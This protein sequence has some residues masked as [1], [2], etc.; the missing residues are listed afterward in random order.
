MEHTGVSD[1]RHNVG[2]GRVGSLMELGNI[3]IDGIEISALDT[4]GCTSEATVHNLVG[5]TQGFED[6]CMWYVCM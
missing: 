2:V 3:G 4:G 1:Q 5:E 6:L